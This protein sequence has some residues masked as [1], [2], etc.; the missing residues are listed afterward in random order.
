MSN[1]ETPVRRCT[2]KTVSEVAANIPKTRYR[3]IN[4]GISHANKMILPGRL[5]VMEVLYL[6][7]TENFWRGLDESGTRTKKITLITHLHVLFSTVLNDV[8]L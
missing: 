4:K 6:K 2:F 5:K 7:P 1:P 8:K 3:D